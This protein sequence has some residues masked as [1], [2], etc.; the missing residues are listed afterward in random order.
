MMKKKS[1]LIIGIIILIVVLIFFNGYYQ[2]KGSF[3]TNIIFLKLNI[4]LEGEFVKNI[5]ITNHEKYEQNFNLFF[6]NLKDLATIKNKEFS[7]GANEFIETEIYF[8]DNRK[9]IGIHLGKLIIETQIL[10]KE[11]PIILKIEDENRTFAISQ[12]RIPKYSNVYPGGKLGI[13][14]KIFN[15]QDYT[16][17]NIKVKYSIK[18]LDDESILSE[19]EELVIKESFGTTKII[20]IPKDTPYGNY[21]FI[22]SID[23]ENIKSTEGHLFSISKKESGIFSENLKLFMIIILIFVGGILILFIYFVKTRDNLLIRFKKQQND[24]L[25][26]NLK[27]IEDIE[28]LR[29][30]KK[31]IIKKIKTKQKRQRKELK[32]V[33]KKGK[34]SEINKQLDKWRKEGYEMLEIEEE[35]GKVSK[36]DMSKQIKDWRRKGYKLGHIRK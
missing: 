6:N 27:A 29:K 33:R 26:M 10:K 36:G 18:N 16:L 15:L 4:P 25:K 14:I 1:I 23:Y 28:G 3:T 2:K 9:E 32:E 5:K 12:T 11:I 34:K 8:K 22:T 19:E 21:V 31:K 35:I 20:D 24:E 7:L 30:V 13:E 17:H